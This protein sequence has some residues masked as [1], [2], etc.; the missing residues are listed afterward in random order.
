MTARR[1][2]VGSLRDVQQLAGYRNIGSAQLYSDRPRTPRG[3]SASL[4]ESH[5]LKLLCNHSV[6][7]QESRDTLLNAAGEN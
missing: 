4:R 3:G 7:Y 6:N 5:L 2:M 1:P